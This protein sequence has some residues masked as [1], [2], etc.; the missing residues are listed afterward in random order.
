M[1][2]FNGE[3]HLRKALDSILSQT[4]QDFELIISDNASSDKTQQICL[5]YTQKDDRVS[6]Y[7][8]ERNF[9]AVWNF[10][11]VFKLS[12]SP[13]F[14]WAAHDDLIAPTFLHECI[15]VLE[16]DH[17]VV[18]CHS[19]TARYDEFDQVVG[20]Y[21]NG[22]IADSPKPHIRFRDVLWRKAF[23]WMIF[24]VFRRTALIQT[25]L[26]QNF[27]S[28]DWNLPADISLIG[29]IVE[30]PQYLLFRRDH[31]QSYTASVSAR[32]LIIDYRN[33]LAWWTGKRKRTL[34]VLPHW[35]NCLEF[36][37]SVQRAPLKWPERC[38]CYK[39][40][41]K[42]FYKYGW[43]FLTWD[44]ENELGFWRIQMNR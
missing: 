6:Y 29:R 15:N 10:N 8:N 31:P 9:G 13:Y 4:Y 32:H 36:L 23:P 39:E 33:R 5:E 1:P 30:I 19:K 37:K 38:S 26:F 35:R 44:L 21:D 43:G 20:F 17:S 3:K 22:S 7:R 24:G 25:P 2:V 11:R 34:V 28:S 27:L 16:H 18:L 41:G 40:L 42:W 14:K 12:S